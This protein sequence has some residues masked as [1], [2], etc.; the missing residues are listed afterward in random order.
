MKNEMSRSET[1]TGKKRILYFVEA[2]GG[3]VFTYIVELSNKL[4]EKYDVFVAY[5]LRR[6]TPEN[7]Q[8]YFN[9]SVHLIKVENYSR[10]LN[11]W[12]NLKA[13]KEMKEIEQSVHPDVIHLHSSIAGALGRVAFDGKNVP[14]YYTPHGYSF[15]MSNY[16]LFR[17]TA[18]RLVEK[19]C[20]HRNCTTISCSYGE[21]MET[22]KLTSRAIYINNGINIKTLQKLAKS[23]RERPANRKL[24]VFTL[25]RI[26]YQKDPELFNEIAGCFPD[27]EFIWIGDGE[28]RDRLTNK[29]IRVTGWLERLSALEIAMHSD[30]F[31]LTSRW[32]G[33]PMSLLE[34]MYLE[35]LCIVSDVIGNHDV[36][37]NGVNGYVCR[38]IEE[39]KT[40]IA[41]YQDTSAKV[42]IDNAKRDVI[43]HYNTDVMGEKYS[44]IYFGKATV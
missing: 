24:T 19:F 23:V 22:L 18:Y 37:K 10:S 7:Y 28:I 2:M 14:L 32:E 4:S 1:E 5:G 43:E 15:L 30:V 11:L 44:E 9:P 3:G 21:H 36:I 13:I 35:K 31:L 38:S 40:A 42:M 33:L 29:N 12:S 27:A 17:R 20:A 6:Q 16:G 25:G 8:E 39:F 41:S 34:S 26:C